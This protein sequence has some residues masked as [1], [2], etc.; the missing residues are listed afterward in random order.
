VKEKQRRQ[1]P[2]ETAGRLY[3]KPA[4][5]TRMAGT[6]FRLKRRLSSKGVAAWKT[7]FFSSCRAASARSWRASRCCCGHWSACPDVRGNPVRHHEAGSSPQEQISR[8]RSLKYPIEVEARRAAASPAP[9][10]K[11]P[12]F[13]PGFYLNPSNPF[14]R[15]RPPRQRR[16]HRLRHPPRRLRRQFQSPRSWRH[17]AGSWLVGS[18]FP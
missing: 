8:A 16:R 10:T 11:N 3:D 2:L 4:P 1:V 13:P 15:L 14:R 17:G 7:F 6:D 12:A 5:R 9:Q 18:R